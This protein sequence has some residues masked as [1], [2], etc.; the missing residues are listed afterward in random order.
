MEIR[1]NIPL[2]KNVQ[3]HFQCI[4]HMSLRIGKSKQQHWVLEFGI[5]VGFCFFCNFSQDMFHFHMLE[6]YG[7]LLMTSSELTTSRVT[8]RDLIANTGKWMATVKIKESL[9]YK[10]CRELAITFNSN[11]LSVW[12]LDE[13]DTRNFGGMC[14]CGITIEHGKLFQQWIRFTDWW[15]IVF[16]QRYSMP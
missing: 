2:A 14:H 9:R 7:L 15:Q 10:R 1:D 4:P 11:Q 3:K 8:L 6:P 12:Q 16:F 5:C 13:N